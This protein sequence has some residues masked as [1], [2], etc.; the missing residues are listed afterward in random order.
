MAV[1]VEPETL[2]ETI[3]LRREY[4][5]LVAVRDVSLSV[6]KG[7]VVAL[8]G[9]NGAGKS[10]LLKMIAALLEPT[11][12]TARVC[13]LDVRESPRQVHSVIG[14]LPDFYGLYDELQ[15]R[16]YLRYFAMAYRLERAVREERVDRILVMLDL[17]E[18]AGQTIGTLSR[19]MRQRL[20][21]AR[22]LL[23]DPP[24]LLLDEPAAGLDPEARHDLQELF[25]RLAHE[26]KT[27]VVSSHILTELDDY[28]SHIAILDKGNLVAAGQ[29][30]Q[31]RQSFT[32]GRRVRLRCAG[33]TSK[34][35]A[36]LC[37]CEPVKRFTPEEG[38]WVL[39]FVGSDEEL[40]AFLKRLVDGGVQVTHFGEEKGALQ[41]TYLALLRGGRT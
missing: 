7:A 18:K 14:F 38:G 10:T 21:I 3:G 12:G 26:G 41:D 23:H 19:G 6:P 33:D 31:V 9:P 5:D 27:L 35:E 17:G 2:L 36:L 4:G 16:D 34:V 39:S 37:A 40:A 13:G 15:V 22:T 1:T 25:K 30:E 29:A 8:V 32:T 28:C 20:A 24:V 11:R